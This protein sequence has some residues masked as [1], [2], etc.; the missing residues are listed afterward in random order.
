M[1]WM[2]D[3]LTMAVSP[4]GGCAERMPPSPQGACCRGGLT[5]MS[6]MDV[7]SLIADLDG[8]R[9]VTDPA[10]VKRMS[11]DYFWYSP[12]L[13]RQL[14]HVSGDVLVEAQTED[15][16]IAVAAACYRHDVPLTVRGGG[17]G[18]Y[19]QAM[20]LRG[21]VVLDM[22]ALDRLLWVRDGACRV[23]AGK[24]LIRL[25]QELE[26]H[27]Y[28]LR[29]HPSTRAI[30]T[31]GG[32]I[33]GGSGGVGSITWG[34]LREPGN[35][36]GARLVT[37]EERPR[38]LELRGD[39]IPKFNHS[40]GVTGIITELEL[41]LAHREN[42]IEA[43]VAFDDFASAA[44]FGKAFAGA[45]GLVKK[46]CG[47]MAPPIG[48]KFLK[49]IA[50]F[51]APGEACALVMIAGQSWEGFCALAGQH[52]GRVVFDTSRSGEVR[53]SRIP[54]YELCWNHTTLWALKV[55]PTLTYLQT[56]L[57]T[58]DC[59]GLADSL[60]RHFGDEVMY[61][62]EFTRSGASVSCSALQMIRFTDESRLNEIMAYHEQLGC[63]IF[64]PHVFTIEEGGM[65]MVNHVQLAFKREV[66][67]KGLLNPGKMLA[68]DDAAALQTS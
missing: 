33:A 43:V 7:S 30:A 41:P 52:G 2:A 59:V 39:E 24:R 12:V 65:K 42:W 6:A 53:K 19:G 55:E 8:T 68:W 38:V 15:D 31:V 44:S 40:Y 13:K 9:T 20:P 5:G 32:F 37:L 54:L 61:H 4:A 34:M 17:T 60:Q 10:T 35:I 14:D 36:I 45:P 3:G 16:V 62:L 58:D 18:N 28:E 1:G 51:L 26:A 23:Q 47:V 56:L 64:N 66:D 57:P 29:L 25:D 63:R 11:R 21:G 48:Q 67:P 50:P 27:G 22:R 49:P 46:Q